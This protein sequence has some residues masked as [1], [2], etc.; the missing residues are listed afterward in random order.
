LFVLVIQI[1]ATHG[2]DT[3]Y[4]A[5]ICECALHGIFMPLP[6]RHSRHEEAGRHIVG[7]LRTVEFMAAQEVSCQRD[8]R[9]LPRH[10]GGLSKAA[11]Q[12]RSLL[13]ASWPGSGS[14]TINPPG[15]PLRE[16]CGRFGFAFAVI[17]PGDR[18][19]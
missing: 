19:F 2:S 16:A 1:E 11:T 5:P 3:D 12:T 13:M 14:S 4:V 15:G 6:L 7:G 8:L 10:K 18:S 17:A 9:N